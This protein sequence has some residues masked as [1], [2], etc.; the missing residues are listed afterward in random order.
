MPLRLRTSRRGFTLVEVMMVIVALAIIA[1]VVVPQ[2]TTIID[3][4]KNSAMLRD[5]RELSAAIE[6]YRME[7]NG[8]APDVIASDTLVQLAGNLRSPSARKAT[9]ITPC[10]SMILPPVRDI[11]CAS[12]TSRGC[13]PI[14]ARGISRKARS[15][16]RR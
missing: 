10:W 7:H 2:V 3:D 8:A 14:W 4:A 16:R 6:R 15:A 11:G 13:T 9:V 12:A 5:V 1:G